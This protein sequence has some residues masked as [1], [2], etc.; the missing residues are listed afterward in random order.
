MIRHTV[1]V[2]PTKMSGTAG[3]GRAR[4]LGS[5]RPARTTERRTPLRRR[6][7]AQRRQIMTDSTNLSEEQAAQPNL[8][9]TSLHRLVGTW[10]Y[11]AKRRE[12]SSTSGP[13]AAFFCC[14]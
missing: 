11:P 9:L 2:T 1:L 13:K 12:P 7:T 14:S 5:A 6:P 4:R 8:D 10:V 3:D